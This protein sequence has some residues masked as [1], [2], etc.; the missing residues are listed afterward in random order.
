[1]RSAL[2]GALT[3]ALLPVLLAQGLL[4]RRRTPRLPEAASTAGTAGT[5]TGDV[6]RLVVVGDSLAAGVGLADHR[7]SI[8]GLLAERW[9]ERDEVSVAWRVLAQTGLTAGEVAGLVDPAALADADLVVLSVGVNDTKDLHSR[10]RWRRELGDLL[11]AL[12]EAAPAADVLLI[13]IPPM[14]AFPALPRPLADALGARAARLDEDGEAVAAARGPRVRRIDLSL[15]DDD[16]LFAN[17]GFHPSTVIHA[18]LASR[19]LELVSPRC[20]SA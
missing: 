5:G 20:P 2:G 3:T 16:G 9:A 8:A 17:D 7:E 13:A 18:A 11:D 19:A 1:M 15:P 10:K 14:R 6:R 4:V 12:L